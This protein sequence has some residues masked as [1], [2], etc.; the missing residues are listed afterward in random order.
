[1]EPMVRCPHCGHYHVATTEYCPEKGLP[2][3][4]PQAVERN[5]KRNLLWLLILLVVVAL[6]ACIVASIYLVPRFLNAQK[7]NQN[8]IPILVPT[9]TLAPLQTR[10]PALETA[11][12]QATSTFTAEPSVTA[13]FTPEPWQACPDSP[14]LSQLRVGMKAS[15]A[16]D[17]PLPNRVRKDP[18]TSATIIGYIDPGGEVEIL[19]GPSCEQGWTWWKV[20]TLSGDLTGWTAE[21]DKDGYWLIPIP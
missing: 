17:P 11:T 20:K 9:L 21:G 4:Q 18:S 5:S 10:L 8:Q 12:L 15:I 14:Y 19:E 13:T 3:Y 16:L 6:A 2:I 7:N 1:M